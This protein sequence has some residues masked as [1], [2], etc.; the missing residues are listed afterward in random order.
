M[1]II[2]DTG[3]I[4]VLLDRAHPLHERV[5]ECLDERLIVPSLILPEVDYLASRRL[6]PKAVN[7]F[8][9]SLLA[10]ELEYHELEL[11]DLRRA[12][13]IMTQY[14]D[15]QV[16]LV[17]AAVVA[18]AERLGVRRILTVDR[19]HFAMFKPRQLDYLELLP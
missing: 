15:A 14:A 9:G 1:A 10:E 16:G 12:F 4:L 2:A 6:T 3:G 17:D 18:C 8:M 5:L 11:R 7:A 19:R 13:E